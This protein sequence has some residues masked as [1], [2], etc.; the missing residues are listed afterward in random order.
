[1]DAWISWHSRATRAESGLSLPW[2]LVRMARAFSTWP[3]CQSQRGLSG[4]MK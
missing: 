3:F 4:R 1:M 2:Y